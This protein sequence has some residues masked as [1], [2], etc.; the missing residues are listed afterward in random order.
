VEQ[1]RGTLGTFGGVFTPS[2]LTI[3]GIIL[4]LRLGYVTGAAGFGRALV[5]I[6]LANA[7]SVLTSV[8]LSAIATNL[9]VKGGG[10]YYVISRTL[11]V[12]Y[13]GALGLV[14]FLAQSVSIAFYSI[15]FGEAVA[16]IVPWKP[17]WL[18]QFL[19]ALA[20]GGLFVLA[21][22][23]AD[24]ATRFQYV[25]MAV[26]FAALAAFFVG[27]F[28]DFSADRV[29]E[30]LAPAI[31]PEA[32]TGGRL[33]LPFWAAFALF[34]PAVTGFTQGVSMSGD[35]KNPG[36]SIPLGTGLA[37]GLSIVV[38]IGVALLFAGTTPNAELVADYGAMRRISDFPWLVDAGVISATLSSA[39]ASFLGAPRILQS[40]AADRVFPLLGFF[41]KGHGSTENPRR[42]VVLC[43][44][45]ALGTIVM[46]D[47]NVIAPVV[48]MFFL[49]SYG[50]LNY[51]TYIEARANSPSFRPRFRWFHARLSLAGGIG[52][53][54]AMLAIHPTA[55]IVAVVLLFAVYH[56][57]A[58]RVPM[59]RWADSGRSHR[60]QRV[61]DDLYAIAT[62]REHARHW[63]PMVLAFSE[64]RERRARL[65]RFASW[66]EGRSGLTTLIRLVPLGI[67]AGP[68]A[69]RLRRDAEKALRAEIE[70]EKL[71][72]FPRAIVTRDIEDAVR[73]LLQAYGL[74]PVRANTVL[75]NWFD[76]RKGEVDPER[77]RNFARRLRMALRFSCNLVVLSASASDF[78]SVRRTKRT[79]R[80]IDVWH[81]DNAT[82]RL[83][84]L[85]AYLMTRSEPWED[86]RIRLLTPLPKEQSREEALAAMETMLR[87]VRIA[88]EV[89]IVDSAEAA[90]V[91]RHSAGS[92]VVLLPMAVSDEGPTCPYGAPEELLPELGLTALVLAAE[93]IVLDTEPEA[94]EQGEIAQAVDEAEKTAKNLRKTGEEAAKASDLVRETRVKLDEARREGAAQ[95]D[96]AELESAVH[97]AEEEAKRLSRRSAKA[98]AKA[99]SAAEE[100]RTR[101]GDSPAEEPEEPEDPKN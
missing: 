26:L 21:W 51:A 11:G 82:G 59:G 6:L 91:T 64:D 79:D 87:E 78:E 71:P 49:I 32:T 30:N 43:A 73:V 27:G 76:R 16:A 68:Y 53:L 77:M 66:L 46:G 50:L 28:P 14:V 45:I 15:G 40:L 1:P 31:L 13:G 57:I 55:A 38:Y 70:R 63:R 88:A 29:V 89:Q 62:E 41:A 19:A 67:D 8:S 33:T 9:R 7:I 25:V 23:G 92:S 17:G 93:D 75:I 74:G 48:S 99:E 101:A 85:L 18:A 12:E 24:W 60:F 5:I 36:R 96:L 56:Y 80:L 72:A 35:L 69:R 83:N 84:L 95:E 90:T 22:L 65:L 97:E 39:L 42:G 52:C 34:F 58:S 44:A 61:R 3:L 4:F 94:G 2:I 10:D 86:A 20:V 98:R 81:R 100:A 47:L 54:G 37:V